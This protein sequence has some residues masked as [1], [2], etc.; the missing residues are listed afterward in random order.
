MNIILIFI[1]AIVIFNTIVLIAVAGSLYKLIRSS[2]PEDV[3]VSRPK[4]SGELIDFP[5]VGPPTYDLAVF[6]GKA[7]P[8][9]DGMDRRLTPTRNWDGISQ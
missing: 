3:E 4:N 9:T 2:I 8:F 6:D 7:E 5:E 1:L